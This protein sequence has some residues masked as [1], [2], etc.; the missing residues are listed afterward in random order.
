M[1]RMIKNTWYEIPTHYP[2]IEL[3]VMQIM[4]NHLHEIIIIRAVGTAPC[5]RPYPAIGQCPD[6]KLTGTGACPYGIV[7]VV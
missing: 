7:V 6:R 4:P 5:D 3:N 2:G 1:G